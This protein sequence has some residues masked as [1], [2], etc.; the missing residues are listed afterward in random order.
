MSQSK[1]ISVVVPSYN[2]AA[3]INDT[4]DAI[5][6]Q[7][8]VP[9][10][11]LVIDDGSQ[12]NSL[13]I[14]ENALKKCPFEC[15]LITGSNKGLSATLNEG[16]AK[17]DGEYFAYIG[18]D[19]VWLPNFLE[20]RVKL[21]ESRPQAVLAFGHAYLINQKNE[22]I[23]CSKDWTP[24]SDVNMLP[25]LLNG[26]VPL[27]PSVVYRREFLEKY[28]WNENSILEDYE[29]YLK[30][31]TEG[32]FALDTSI[33]CAWR[34]HNYNVSKDF[35]L[36]LEEWLAAQ[37]RVS[38]ELNIS[39]SELKEIQEILKFNSGVD[40]IRAGKKREAIR[41][42]LENRNGVKS[43]SKA[44]EILLRLAT[45]QFVFQRIR[46]QKMVQN[47]KKYGKVDIKKID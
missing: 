42:I 4:L 10:K 8:L 40:L 26:I 5:F 36:M 14:I 1:R 35:S 28:G 6:Q 27:S 21:L 9:Q 13:Q 43:L 34:Q 33:L 12:D 39:S 37:N 17:T 3:F 7:T 32:E 16:L 41:L 38:E 2:H 45:P 47:I 29:L 25:M 19:D 31:T 44:L 15:E 30:L 24:Y 20:E 11:L 46:K 23:D 22:I 18:S